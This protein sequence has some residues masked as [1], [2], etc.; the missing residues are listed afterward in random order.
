MTNTGLVK[1]MQAEVYNYNTYYYKAEQYLKYLDGTAYKHI[2][3]IR[4]EF[5]DPN[6]PNPFRIID[7]GDW[8]L[9]LADHAAGKKH[10]ALCQ[11]NSKGKIQTTIILWG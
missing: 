7:R 2:K 9:H 6:G 8:K 11:Y 4:Y 3:G 10:Y 1:E 5:N